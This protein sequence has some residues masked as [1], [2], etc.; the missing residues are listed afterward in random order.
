MK[1]DLELLKEFA[2]LDSPAPILACHYIDKRMKFYLVHVISVNVKEKKVVGYANGMIMDVFDQAKFNKKTTSRLE[3]FMGENNFTARKKI[4]LH[5]AI[6]SKAVF[7]DNYSFILPPLEKFI[8][9]GWDM[10]T[11]YGDGGRALL[12]HPLFHSRCLPVPDE[13]KA[14]LTQ[15]LDA[16]GQERNDWHNNC[17]V[18]DI[19]DPDLAPN[20]FFSSKSPGKHT[21]RLSYAWFPLDVIVGRN[22]SL[23]LLGPIHNLPPM[24]NTQLYHSIFTVFKK[25]LPGFRKLGIRKKFQDYKLQVVVKAQKYVIAPGT[26]YSGKWHV[27]GRTENIVAGGVY[28]CKIDKGFKKDVVVFRPKVG[29]E[30][31]YAKGNG[32]AMENEIDI[33]EGCAIVFSNI[34]PHKFLKLK[35]TTDSPLERLFLNFFIIDPTKELESTTFYWES[36][37]ALKRLKKLPTVIIAHILSFV[38]YLPTAAEA[39]Q[40]RK[41][42]RE[43]MMSEVSGWGF[44]HYGNCGDVEFIDPSANPKII[45]KYD[46]IKGADIDNF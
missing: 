2:S 1:V 31:Y 18:L 7:S 35:N 15:A 26:S 37:K 8:K 32:I 13:V 11:E 3:Y 25:M 4:V 14:A 5:T 10:T 39:K 42:A 20:F 19:I 24:G 16:L 23:K 28:Y 38:C 29:P 30:S 17:P 21:N 44:I 9:V 6:A 36:T 46:K 33:T 45:E 22:D 27:E 34:L 43:S 12:I 41:S 40:R